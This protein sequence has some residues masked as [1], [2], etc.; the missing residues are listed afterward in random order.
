MNIKLLILC[1]SEIIIKK[2]HFETVKNLNGI[3]LFLLG[4]SVSCKISV[5]S[6]QLFLRIS[7]TDRHDLVFLLVVTNTRYKYL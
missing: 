2:P 5:E 7:K 4:I 3:K 6:V 1:D